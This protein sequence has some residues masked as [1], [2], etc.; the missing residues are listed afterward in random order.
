M[1]PG[2]TLQL[3]TLFGPDGDPLMLAIVLVNG[4]PTWF[5]IPGVYGVDRRHD[6]V[7]T[8]PGGIAADV[9]FQAF[10]RT[11]CG[12]VDASPSRKVTFK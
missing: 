7:V 4:T 9:T 1:W 10:G 8:T 5:G 12:S 11:L 6:L 2:D 3:S